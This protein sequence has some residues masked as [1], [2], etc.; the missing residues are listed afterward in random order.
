MFDSSIALTNPQQSLPVGTFLLPICIDRDGV[1]KLLS[2][3]FASRNLDDPSGTDIEFMMPVLEALGWTETPGQC[4]CNDVIGTPEDGECTAYTNRQSLITFAPADPRFDPEFVPPGYTFP[5]F[6]SP[7]LST[8]IITTLER[9]PYEAVLGGGAEPPRFRV[10]FTGAGTVELHMVAVPLGGLAIATID[11]NPL[12][13]VTI[14]LEKDFFSLPPSIVDE[15]VAELVVTGSG[16]HHIDVTFVPV[17]DDEATAPL[18]FGGGIRSVVLCGTDIT[19]ETT[20][21]NF[22]LSQSGCQLLLTIDG[23]TPQVV[24]DSSGCGASEGTPITYRRKPDVSPDTYILQVSIDGGAHW[25]DTAYN[26][27][28]MV[29]YRANIARVSDYEGNPVGGA[30]A[31]DSET[32]ADGTYQENWAIEINKAVFKGDTGE[33]GSNGIT[34]EVSLG[35]LQLEWYQYGDTGIVEYPPATPPNKNWLLML[36]KGF[37]IDQTGANVEMIAHGETGYVTFAPT[38]SPGLN[39]VYQKITFHIPAPLDGSNGSNGSNGSDGIT[40]TIALGSVLEGYPNETP[41]VTLTP[42]EENPNNYLLGFKLPRAPHFSFNEP[43]DRAPGEYAEVVFTEDTNGDWIGQ[44][45]RAQ[46]ATGATG[47]TGATGGQGEPGIDGTDGVGIDETPP[48][49]GETKHYKFLVPA[50]GFMIPFLFQAGWTISNVATSGTWYTVN[51]FFAEQKLPSGGNVGGTFPQPGDLYILPS[52]DTGAEPSGYRVFPV[53]DK[54]DPFSGNFVAANECAVLLK[55]EYDNVFDSEAGGFLGT[56]GEGWIMVDCDITAGAPGLVVDAQA[57]PGGVA[58]VEYLGGHVY[59]VKNVQSGDGRTTIAIK[60]SEGNPINGTISNIDVIS[61]GITTTGTPCT[62]PSIPTTQ[63]EVHFSQP[64]AN[65]GS[66][67]P[68]TPDSF[69]YGDYSRLDIWCR[70]TLE[71]D[72]TVSPVA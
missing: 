27:A 23:G 4:P 43:I 46:G 8:D 32:L 31:E 14:A 22:V 56:I 72:I 15:V 2:H 61:W 5:P 10:H 54:F 26:L 62:S 24:F 55:Q 11:D 66:R 41:E 59:K 47:E 35:L 63:C 34:P 68:S 1:D 60:D 25:I 9:F 53:S 52:D 42:D 45:Y 70:D 40:P 18:K 69:F 38:D 16:A 20:T 19:A 33:P 51:N 21:M 29:R 6:Y 57:D 36:P 44:P 67:S 49:S 13:A 65:F 30:F 7:P 58:T 3:L 39:P 64:F 50:T 17:L 37:L 48:D 12:S 71:V 28:G